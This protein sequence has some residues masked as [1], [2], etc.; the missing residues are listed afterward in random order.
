LRTPSFQPYTTDSVIELAEKVEDFRAVQ[1]QVLLLGG[2]KSP[3]YLRAALDGLG[4]VLPRSKR[5]VFPGLDHLG[6]DND[7]KPERVAQELRCFFGDLV[8]A[9]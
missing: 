7:G 6:P 5:V 3:A 8:S 4:R 1:P 2:S 9:P